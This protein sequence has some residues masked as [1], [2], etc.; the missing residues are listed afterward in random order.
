[1][2]WDGINP[3]PTI[4]CEHV[5]TRAD[6]DAGYGTAFDQAEV[7]PDSNPSTNRYATWEKQ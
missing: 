4:T 2:L 7:L 1:M 5:Y 6:A 3:S